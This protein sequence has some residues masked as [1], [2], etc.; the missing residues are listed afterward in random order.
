MIVDASA[1]GL[2]LGRRH[3]DGGIPMMQWRNGAIWGIGEIEGGEYLVNCFAREE[4][5]DRLAEIVQ[6]KDDD[7]SDLPTDIIENYRHI[8]VP[9]GYWIIVSSAS[10]AI[11]SR[12][13]TRKFLQELDRMNE[14]T[15]RLFTSQQNK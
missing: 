11:I 9:S 2:I 8:I 14:S 5:L 3:R 12:S 6:Y 7:D 15:V 1:G 13:G 4:N 10:G